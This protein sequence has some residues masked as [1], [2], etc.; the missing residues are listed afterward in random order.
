[1]G[2]YAEPAL[3]VDDGELGFEATLGFA[4]RFSRVSRP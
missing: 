2:I 1:M 4:W 3:L